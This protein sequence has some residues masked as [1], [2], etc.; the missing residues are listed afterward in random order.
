[1]IKPRIVFDFDHTLAY[2]DG[3]WSATILGILQEHG[4]DQFKI[5]DIRNGMNPGF[6]WDFYEKSHEELLIDMSWWEYHEKFVER[7]LLNNNLDQPEAE[8]LSKFIKDRYLNQK[9]WFLFKDTM[10]ALEELNNQKYKCY[11][12]SNHVPELEDLVIGLGIRNCFQKIYNSALIGYEKP[13]TKIYQHMI[14]D[15]NVA[16]GDVVMIGDNYVSDVVG[17]RS[18]GMRAILVRKE[19]THNYRYYSESLLDIQ[20][21]IEQI[22][23]V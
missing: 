18:N 3:M 6:L 19:N 16:P 8:R 5:E 17:A 20:T 10:Q 13:N 21:L 7:I 1:M 22:T 11:I 4:Y 12:L 23:K 2:R 9:K 14:S 15:L